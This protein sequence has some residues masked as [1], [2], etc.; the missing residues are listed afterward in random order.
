MSSIDFNEI[1]YAKQNSGIYFFSIVDVFAT[2]INSFAA[3]DHWDALKKF[4]ES[5][6]GNLSSKYKLIRFANSDGSIVE[7]YGFHSS[8]ILELLSTFNLVEHNSLV[9]LEIW[10]NKINS[11]E[12]CY[13]LKH[14]DISVIEIEINNEGQIKSYNDIKNKHHL[15]VG[16]LINNKFNFKN[17]HMWWKLR[18][19]PTF[20][21]GLKNLLANLSLESPIPLLHNCLG[22]SLSDHY[23]ICPLNK[24]LLWSEVNFYDN[25]YSDD[26]G[27][28]LFGNFPISNM[29]INTMSPDCAT[30]GVLQKRWQ[31][32]DGIRYLIKGGTKPLWQ[33]P[34]NEILASKICERLNI[35]HVK[36]DLIRIGNNFFSKCANF[37]DQIF[38]F[39]PAYFITKLINSEN[40]SDFDAFINKCEEFGINDARIRIN[41]ML[42]LDYIIANTDR[43]YNNFGIIRDSKTLEWKCIAP[44]FDSGTSLW[45]KEPNNFNFDMTN[46]QSKPFKCNHD[47]QIEFVDDFSR[48]VF[49]NLDGI[50]QEFDDILKSTTSQTDYITK[51][52]ANLCRAL[53]KR[54]EMIKTIANRH[55]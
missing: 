47:K 45:C 4:D 29:H 44:V 54:I 2:L 53:E 51:R 14:N 12:L 17:L 39:V 40:S 32:I 46:V 38:E 52:N 7:D 37:T 42:I 31:I 30:D 6:N 8:D 10:F 43:H 48:L 11:G 20:R 22:L 27:N 19:I 15:P 55:N 33:E 23:W 9:Q 28:F 35:P 16:T 41:Q 49:E 21:D 25:N 24:N 26:V 50:V 13:I 1:R 18:S 34:I 5:N 36:Y 3:R